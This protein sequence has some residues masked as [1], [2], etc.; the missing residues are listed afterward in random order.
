MLKIDAH[1]H[2]DFNNCNFKKQIANMDELG[3]EKAILLTWEA[4][5]EENCMSNMT[6]CP[7]P[8]YSNMPIPFERCLDFY[9]KAPDRYILG[10]CPDPRRP[11]A[12]YQMKSAI[13]TY[14]VKV[15]GEV[16]YRM[17]YDNPD[18]V[19]LFRYCGEMGVPA[20]LHFDTPYIVSHPLRRHYWHGGDIFTLERTLQLCP[21]TNFLGHAPGFWGC[22]SNDDLWKSIEYPEGYPVIPGGHIERLLDKYPN[23]YCDCSAGSAIIALKRDREYTKKLILRHPDRFIFA[24]DCLNNEHSEFFDSLELPS[25]IYEMFYH[26]NIERL[27][28]METK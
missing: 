27:I 17:M 2:P 25:E 4:P 21:E 13:E 1:S 28:G 6:I 7:S 24:R 3:I 18:I 11:E 19:D 5:W 12:I 9:D 15:C 14:G 22:I 16:K 26:K 10:Y 23:L 8:M 20:I